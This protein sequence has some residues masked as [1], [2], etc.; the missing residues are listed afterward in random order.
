M[1][2]LPLVFIMLV[3]IHSAHCADKND[4][5]KT[6]LDEQWQQYKVNAN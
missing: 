2:L 6:S 3:A 1:K 4:D 5:K